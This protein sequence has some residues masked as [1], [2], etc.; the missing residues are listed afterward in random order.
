MAG[1]HRSCGDIGFVI[2]YQDLVFGRVSA[3]FLAAVECTVRGGAQ[4]KH[5]SAMIDIW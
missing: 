3:D 2:N 1:I 5:S 4:K